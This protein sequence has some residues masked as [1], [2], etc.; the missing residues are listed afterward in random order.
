MSLRHDLQ[1][2]L[3]KIRTF[4]DRLQNVCGDALDETGVQCVQRMQNAAE[5]MQELIEGLLTLSRVTTKAADFVS[6]DLMKVAAEVVSD[7]E[8]KIEQCGGRVGIR[9]SADDPG[10]PAAN[11]ATFAESGRQRAEVS[12][13]GSEAAGADFRPNG[14]DQGPRGF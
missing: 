13:Q 6:V 11:A 10:R 8:V 2:P 3:R 7:L 1:E 9:Q 4:G 14:Q 5:R 12:A